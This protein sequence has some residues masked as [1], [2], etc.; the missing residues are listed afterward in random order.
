MMVAAHY[1]I[2]INCDS[3]AIYHVHS[4]RRKRTSSVHQDEEITRFLVRV[5]KK[6]SSEIEVAHFEWTLSRR[7]RPDNEKLNR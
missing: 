5:V 2:L 1:G 6:I 7:D 3:F 4:C